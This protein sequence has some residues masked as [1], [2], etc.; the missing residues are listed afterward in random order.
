MVL[1]ERL[2]KEVEDKEIL[3]E[4]Q[5]GFKRGRSTMDNVYN[6]YIL[7]HVVEKEGKP[8]N[9]REIFSYDFKLRLQLE[10]NC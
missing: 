10:T 2:R 8:K 6:I 3:P 7:Q 5:A 4:S 1:T 9:E